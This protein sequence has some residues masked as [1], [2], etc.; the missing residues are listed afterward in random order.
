[1]DLYILNEVQRLKGSGPSAESLADNPMGFENLEEYPNVDGWTS[2]WALNWRTGN[3]NYNWGT[4]HAANSSFYVYGNASAETAQALMWNS[5]GFTG[6]GTTVSN[7]DCIGY[8]HQ[9]HSNMKYL[10]YATSAHSNNTSSS[11]GPF[12]T[13]VVFVR[14]PTK[15]DITTSVNFYHSNYWSS[16]YEGSS[17]ALFTPNGA[18]YDQT[19]G[20]TWSFPFTQTSGNSF[21][22]DTV[23]ITVPAGKTCILVLSATSL[24]WTSSYQA[25]L[26]SNSNGIGNVD[27]LSATGLECDHAM[28]QVYQQIGLDQTIHNNLYTTASTAQLYQKA[29]QYFGDR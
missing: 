20:G 15:S 8:Q 9:T 7:Y 3:S 28:S 10:G 1:M 26:W 6:N 16:G 19:T 13:N 4:S 25:G 12:S 27:A 5:R 18:K 14:N 17:V 22:S 21:Y 24:Y 11:N 23:S 2:F 29:A